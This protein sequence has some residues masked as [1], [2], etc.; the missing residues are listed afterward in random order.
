MPRHVRRRQARRHR[1]D[2]EGAAISDTLIALHRVPQVLAATLAYEHTDAMLSERMPASQS[3]ALIHAITE[4]PCGRL[5]HDHQPTRLHQDPGGRHRRR[6]GRH[7][8]AA[9]AKGAAAAEN[10]AG[11]L[12]QGR[13]PLLRHR[14]LGAGGRAE[15]PRG[16]HPGRP[17]RA[18][19]RGPRCIKATS[20][21]RSCTAGPLTNARC[22]A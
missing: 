7:L 6:H 5:N 21:P 18:V 12:G 11:A 4:Y 9:G 22:C 17:G 13:L 1:G 19:N 20:C 3:Q 16:R 10:T 8:P 15:R 2:A 14:L